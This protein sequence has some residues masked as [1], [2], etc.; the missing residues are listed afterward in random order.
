MTDLTSAHLES[1]CSRYVDLV[2]DED[3]DALMELFADE[4]SVEDP[5]GSEL[6]VG[7]DEVRAFFATLP[8]TGVKGRLV[9]PVHTV[10]DAAAAAFPFE[11]DT[12]GFLM[13][14][15]DVMTFD[16]RGKI[17]SMTAYWKM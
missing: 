8:S 4:C 3:V 2:G 7:R 13:S 15:I 5:V 10:P 1:V 6:R 9:G 12:D 17:V 11:L 16:E 14:V